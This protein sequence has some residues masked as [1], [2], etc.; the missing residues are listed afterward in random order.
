MSTSET[1]VSLRPM[2]ED[3]LSSVGIIE[4]QSYPTPWTRTHFLDEMNKPFAR[5]YVLTDDETDSMVIGYIVYWL[6]AEGVSLLNIAID[7]KWRGFG[8]GMKLMQAMIK[9]AVQEDI[10]K[11]MLEV[12]E[13]NKNAI[14]LYESI[15]FKVTH[16]RKKF[17]ADGENALVMEIKTSDAFSL[18]SIH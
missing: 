10:S 18:R 17:Y 9:E 13:S 7:P 3:D 15:G 16:V 2:V 11:V 12:R 8:F 4:S 5:C 14:A 1:F 6:Q